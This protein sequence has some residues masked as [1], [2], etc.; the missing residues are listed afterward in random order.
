MS[1]TKLNVEFEVDTFLHMVTGNP[2]TIPGLYQSI[3]EKVRRF[4]DDCEGAVPAGSVVKISV[5]IV[6]GEDPPGLDP[7]EMHELEDLL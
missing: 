2:T 5:E 3:T 6:E 4:V 7:D 1:K